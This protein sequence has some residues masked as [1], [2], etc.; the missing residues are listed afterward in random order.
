LRDYTPEAISK[1][2]PIRYSQ[3]KA[4]LIACRGRERQTS[5]VVVAPNHSEG[6]SS[7]VESIDR[8]GEREGQWQGLTG[9]STG[10]WA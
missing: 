6:G 3:A 7:G 1:L 2:L 9:G 5:A 8:E 10:A 4:Q